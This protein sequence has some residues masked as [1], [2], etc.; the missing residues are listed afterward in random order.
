M[1]DWR[2]LGGALSWIAVGTLKWLWHSLPSNAAG[3]DT[4]VRGLG[5]ADALVVVAD[6][7]WSC[8]SM[9]RPR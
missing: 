5:D 6:L 9:A 3:V 8:H 4:L 7:V 1:R 2:I